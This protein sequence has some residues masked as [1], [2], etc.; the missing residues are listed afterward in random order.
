MRQLTV[1]NS[2][3]ALLGGRDFVSKTR[4]KN[5]LAGENYLQFSLPKK[6]SPIGITKIMITYYFWEDSYSME[7]ISIN[8]I[9]QRETIV[10]N[11]KKLYCDNLREVFVKETGLE[12]N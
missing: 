9:I 11:R 10:V 5:F 6:S 4:A 7:F 2:I 1:A 12:L 3:L 8:P